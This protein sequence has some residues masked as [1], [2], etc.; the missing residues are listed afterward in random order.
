[1]RLST[2]TLASLA[3]FAASP[4]VAQE[5]LHYWDFST[6]HDVV[7]GIQSNVIGT[8]DLSLNPTYGEAYPGAGASL[9]TLINGINGGSGFLEATVFTGPTPGLQL[10]MDDYSVSCWVYD[11]FASDMDVTGPRLFDCLSGTT[12]GLQHSG[13]NTGNFIFRSDDHLGSVSIATPTTGFPIQNQWYHVAVVVDRAA[14]TISFYVNGALLE[15]LPFVNSA[16]NA[17]LTGNIAPSQDLWIGSINGGTNTGQAQ[18]QGMDD[19]AFFRGQLQPTDI[20]GLATGA[21]TPNDFRRVGAALCSPATPNST[22]APAVLRAFGSDVASANDLT[23][24]VTQLPSSSFGYFVVSQETNLIVTPGNSVG[25]LC[26]ASLT[27]GRYSA[28]TLNTG[29]GSSVAL[30]LDLTAIPVQPSGPVA[31]AAGATWYW[32][33]WYR[34][35]DMSGGSISNF[36]DAVC[37]IFN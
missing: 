19:L 24:V 22:L 36:S 20:A 33:Y 37:V 4:A 9:N 5:V 35:T 11:D 30:E 23:L 18:T 7:G 8:P 15:T 1:M 31:A 21:L 28:S 10:G 13:N 32:Q 27:M 25:D 3:L 17:P 14:S 26:I 2:T 34:D 6:P 29:A 12:T 16:N